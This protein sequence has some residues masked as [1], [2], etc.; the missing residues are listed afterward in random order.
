MRSIPSLGCRPSDGGTDLRICGAERRGKFLHLRRFAG[1][2]ESQPDPQMAVA[3]AGGDIDAL[4]RTD[5]GK[6]KKYVLRK[7][8]AKR[9]GISEPQGAIAAIG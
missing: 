9:M 6:I 4:P 2:S 3:G 1:L 8:I 7:D 5:S